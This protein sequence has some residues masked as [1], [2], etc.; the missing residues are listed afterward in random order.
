MFYVFGH[1]SFDC[2][3][4]LSQLKSTLNDYSNT[5]IILFYDP[6]YK[7]I[8]DHLFNL[9]SQVYPFSYCSTLQHTFYNP[10]TIN[11]V[12][13]NDNNDNNNNN[14]NNNNNKFV[15]NGREYWIP[16]EDKTDYNLIYI[17]DE[18][19]LFLTN[20]MIENNKN[21]IY[22]YNVNKDKLRQETLGVSKTLMTRYYLVQKAKESQVIGIL[23]GT[24]GVSLYLDVILYLKKL[25]KQSNR[26]YYTFV[27]GK[28][29]VPKLANFQEIDM[30]VL[31]A[32]PENSLIDSKEFYKPIITPFE[33]QLALIKGRQWTGE[34]LT[35]F[36]SI[37][38]GMNNLDNNSIDNINNGD[39]NNEEEDTDYSFI[40]GTIKTMNKFN[41]TKS[42]KD[43]NL[44]ENNSVS[45]RNSEK[46]METWSP[47]TQFLT[48]RTY[49]GNSFNKWSNQ[50]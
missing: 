18:N 28:L 3:S 39:D 24:L 20:L 34:Y 23:V 12:N 48:Q 15:F 45:V 30:F 29:N 32:C 16:D 42:K 4:F 14:N 26:K 36:S 33:L 31:V 38:P 7:S 49:R 19:S 5:K 1:V 35:D 17:G 13:V 27:V 11:N 46:Q 47:A 41:N 8:I 2:Q 9:I 44:N 37:L 43:D 50:I 40:S 21:R 25:L 6:I 10:T 22:S